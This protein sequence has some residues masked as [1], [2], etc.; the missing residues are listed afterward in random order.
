MVVSTLP[1]TFS[2]A[3]VKSRQPRDVAAFAFAGL[4]RSCGLEWD[5][6]VTESSPGWSR[7]PVWCLPCGVAVPSSW[8]VD[9]ALGV[10]GAGVV[11]SG[12]FGSGYSLIG[13]GVWA[14]WGGHPIGLGLHDGS[15]GMRVWQSHWYQGQTFG[16]WEL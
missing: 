13:G 10:F 1:F 4:P 16:G 11:C 5:S 15:R 12:K 14:G 2:G 9:R 7:L 8:P 6:P 3:R